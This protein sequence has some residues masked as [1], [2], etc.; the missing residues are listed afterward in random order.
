MSYLLLLL[1]IE[2][3]FYYIGLP[4]QSFWLLNFIALVMAP[5]L[6]PRV[7]RGKVGRFVGAVLLGYFFLITFFFTFAGYH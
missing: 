5:F 3:L 4:V 6:L 1:P 2:S 7:F